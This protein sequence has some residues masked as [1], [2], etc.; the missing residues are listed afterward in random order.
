[1]PEEIKPEPEVLL[2]SSKQAQTILSLKPYAFNKLARQ[3]YF[4]KHPAK[5]NGCL[6]L[7][8]EI[9]AFV[10]LIKPSKKYKIDKDKDDDSAHGS[11]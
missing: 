8:S 3:G 7:L 10:N 11:K 6:Y 1:M 5:R 2:V 9:K 4:S